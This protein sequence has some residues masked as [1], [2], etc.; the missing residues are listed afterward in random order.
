MAKDREKYDGSMWWKPEQL[1][2]ANEIY[3]ELC[4]KLEDFDRSKVLRWM[5]QKNPPYRLE[6]SLDMHDPHQGYIYVIRDTFLNG[7]KNII[8]VGASREPWIAVENHMTKSSVKAMRAYMAQFRSDHIEVLFALRQLEVI[9]LFENIISDYSEYP[10][11]KGYIEF[12]WEVVDYAES[13]HARNMAPRSKPGLGPKMAMG[14]TS[15]RNYY[16][17]L[18]RA[19]GHPILNGSSGRPPKNK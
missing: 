17:E 8:F 19:E 4:V 10:I 1:A 14:N 15:L 16:T 11:P 2:K 12:V 9:D 18:Y 3:D 13:V 5:Y 7:D 6:S